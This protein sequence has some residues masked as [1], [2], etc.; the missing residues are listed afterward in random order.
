MP[1]I[2]PSGQPTVGRV[3]S[4]PEAWTKKRLA[5]LVRRP[6]LLTVEQ[7]KELHSFLGQH[8]SAFCLEEQE[9][10]ETDLVEM[11]IHTKDAD[12]K[13][14][15]ARRMPFAVRQEVARQ[16][17]EMQHNGVIQPSSSPWVSPVVM[18]RKKDGTHRFCIDYRDLNAAT[19]PDTFLLPRIDDLLDQLG[20]SRFFSTL[21]L[22]SGYWQI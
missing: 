20:Q 6:E 16:L 10:G 17:R 13:K 15:P 5:D 9:W 1:E 7:T 21:D 3:Q 18:V 4:Q 2:L 22:A 11:E 14:V 19:V 12:P 8:H